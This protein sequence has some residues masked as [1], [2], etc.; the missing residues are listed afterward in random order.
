MASICPAEKISSFMSTGGSAAK[1]T[2][3]GNAFSAY[4]EVYGKHLRIHSSHLARIKDCIRFVEDPRLKNIMFE[5]KIPH[6][7]PAEAEKF[8]KWLREHPTTEFRA[9]HA[10]P[11]PAEPLRKQI[12]ALEQQK[13]QI[14]ADHTAKI[15]Q[16]TQD[17]RTAEKEVAALTAE[18]RRLTANGNQMKR[19][20]TAERD[21]QI[22]LKTHSERDSR[23]YKSQIA[24]LEGEL[25]G[26]NKIL[27]MQRLKQSKL[28]AENARLTT[29]ASTESHA[30]S[31]RKDETP[32]RKSK[33]TSP[34]IVQAACAVPNLIMGVSASIGELAAY[35]IKGPAEPRGRDDRK[36]KRCD[37][38][39]GEGKSGDRKRKRRDSPR[40]EGGSGSD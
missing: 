20:L 14:Q 27:D 40:G 4:K 12:E 10:H 7:M 17:K 29:E 23:V 28:S 18:T 36:R 5:D 13:R 35:A 38:P 33:D 31:T 1:L 34:W 19:D 26:A 15:E 16:L 2:G 9:S 8:I 37:S 39:Q 32:R 6:A 11:D 22:E 21:A 25:D 3:I 30:L 24:R